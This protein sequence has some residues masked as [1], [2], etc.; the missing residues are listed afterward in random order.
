MTPIG[1]AELVLLL[2]AL[3]GM[4]AAANVGRDRAKKA[5]KMNVKRAVK[6]S[7]IAL[8]PVVAEGS[9]LTLH[10]RWGALAVLICTARIPF[11][12]AR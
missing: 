3:G 4:T 11:A 10:A 12:T 6:K 2:V 1:T 5:A 9:Y 8:G 7:E